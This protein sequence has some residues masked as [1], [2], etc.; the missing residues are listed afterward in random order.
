MAIHSTLPIYKVTYDLL[1]LVTEFS[2]NM[3]RDF[4]AS[5]GGKIR[6]ECVD[7]VV[8]IYRANCSF[9]KTTLLDE[10]LERLQVI[11]LMLRLSRDLRFISIGQYARSIE[12]TD[13][14]GKQANGW[15]KSSVPAP[16]AEQPRLL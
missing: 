2:R 12:L 13:S 14:I 3:P 9:S 11:E 16:V 4:K 7:L 6:E 10:M 5:L 1:R 8:L 15:R